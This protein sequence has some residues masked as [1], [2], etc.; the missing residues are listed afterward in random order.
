MSEKIFVGRNK[1]HDRDACFYI[2]KAEFEYGYFSTPN[3]IGPCYSSGWEVYEGEYAYENIETVLTKKEY[4]QFRTL[5]KE[6]NSFGS[7]LNK[8]ENVEKL[9]AAQA[10][11]DELNDFIIKHLCSDK[12]EKFKAKIAKSEKEYMMEEYNLEED[13]VDEIIENYGLDYFDNGIISYVYDSS[14]DVAERAIDD[15][16]YGN[17]SEDLKYYIDYD[18]LGD[19]L[20][21]NDD[22]YEL[23]DGR[24]VEYNY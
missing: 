12:A 17:I 16:V 8:S 2:E 14:Y 19:D 23:N 7:G 9:K 11:S 1:K 5:C 15:C 3:P 4:Q 13:E 6:L 18:K 22:Y 21:N 20:V 24:V 10:K